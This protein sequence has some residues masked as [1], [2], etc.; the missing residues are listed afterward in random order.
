MEPNDYIKFLS[1]TLKV[2]KNYQNYNKIC[3]RR[4]LPVFTTARV[5]LVVDTPGYK[6]FIL[7]RACKMKRYFVNHHKQYSRHNAASLDSLGLSTLNI[8]TNLAVFTH[9]GELSYHGVSSL[10]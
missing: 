6:L 9:Y 7:Y 4:P 1:L 8:H 10:F 5:M 3:C 2:Y